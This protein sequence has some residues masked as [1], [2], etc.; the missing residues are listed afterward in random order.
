VAVA[1]DNAPD[2][3]NVVT[4]D[5]LII[6]GGLAG[7]TAAETIRALGARG[8]VA[9][10]SGEIDPP[11]DRPPL[12]K[13]LLRDERSRQQVLLRPLEFYQSRRIG[14]VL[15][16]PALALKPEGQ[17]VTLADGETVKYQRLLL[18]TGGRPRSIGVPGE[19]LAGIYQL[20]TLAEAE[21]LKEAAGA[22]T[23]VVIIGASF[24]GLEV[25]ASLSERGLDVTVLSQDSQIWPSVAPPEIAAAIQADFEAR[26]VR[27]R[28]NV[29]V[30]GFEGK[31]SLEYIV[32]NVGDVEASFVVEGV[33]IHLNT[34]LAAAA[35][36][37]VDNGIVVDSRLQTS[38]PGIFAAGDVASFPDVYAGLDLKPKRHHVEHWDNAVAQGRVAGANMAG[39]RIRF[40][41]VSYFWTD[42]F[43][44]SVNVVGNLDG[45]EIT[46]L[47][48]SLERRQCTHLVLRGGYVRGALMLNRAAD[49]KA[50]TELI[51]KRVPIED[52]LEQLADPTFK[53]AGLVPA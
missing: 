33:G 45:G 8:S 24:I 48:G 15:G 16:R 4:I 47:R 2:S 53:L 14:L 44:H 6:G 50:L 21:R 22:S 39:K 27:F 40:E 3:T 35:G 11:H 36:L 51:G 49:R 26:G 5:Y 42:L 10:V 1:S 12:S 52:R 7:V 37:E 17:E 30:T 46:M 34:E 13:E 29:R 38:V 25:A 28:H 31:D 23:R 41:H 19:S 43:E 32:T 18:A 20:R 9:I